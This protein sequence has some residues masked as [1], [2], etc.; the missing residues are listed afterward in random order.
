MQDISIGEG[1]KRSL[2][3]YAQKLCLIISFLCAMISCHLGNDEV[4]QH[5]QQS[6]YIAFICLP[7]SFLYYEANERKRQKNK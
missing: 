4:T 3:V 7:P 6:D 5:Q 1:K 2:C